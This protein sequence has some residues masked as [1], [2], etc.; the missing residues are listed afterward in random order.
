MGFGYKGIL[1]NAKDDFIIYNA[2]KSTENV[3]NFSNEVRTSS[4]PK[5]EKPEV[6]ISY[7]K[8]A[9]STYMKDYNAYWGKNGWIHLRNEERYNDN[10]KSGQDYD[11]K[12]MSH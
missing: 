10:T 5:N 8:D 3:P 6:L 11:G 7:D 4:V 9:Y 12:N 2:D 1:N